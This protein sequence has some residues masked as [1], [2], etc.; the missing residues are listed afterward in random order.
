MSDSEEEAASV[1]VDIGEWVEKAKADPQAYLERQATEVFLTALGMTKPFCH[2]VFLKG[3]ILMGVVYDSPRQT[4]DIDFTTIMNPDP[5]IADDIKEALA[6]NFPRVAAEIGYP[7][8]MCNVQSARYYPSAKMFPKAD[9]PAMKLKIGYARRGSNQEKHFH[10]GRAVDVL[11]VDISFREPVGA[12]QIVKF[13]STGG[14]VRAY[15]LLDLL[16]EKLR[17][18]LQQ[19]IRDRYR[20]QDIYDIDALLER[21]SLDEDEK[22]KLFDLLGEKC[23][24]RKVSPD[25]NSLS[26]PD[27]IK[28]ARSEWNTLKLEISEVPDFDECFARVDAFYRSLPWK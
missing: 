3:G 5:K 15:S 14:E 6:A 25:E 21:F 27:I 16:A 18:L 1:T 2:E 24:A 4:G 9:G 7:D 19:E 26:H 10:A 12:I 17:A 11:E 22:K 28:R 13:G 20:R 23:R 8:L